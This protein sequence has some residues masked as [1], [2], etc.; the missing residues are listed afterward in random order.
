V[1]DLTVQTELTLL[2]LRDHIT[3]CTKALF[4]KLHCTIAWLNYCGHNTMPLDCQITNSI[5][6]TILLSSLDKATFVWQRSTLSV[7]AVSLPWK[8]YRSPQ[9]SPNTGQTLF[10]MPSQQPSLTKQHEKNVESVL[11]TKYLTFENLTLKKLNTT[12]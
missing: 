8:L 2:Q 6:A 7:S 10:R 3:V 4:T 11:N 5:P 1:N 12:D 9:W